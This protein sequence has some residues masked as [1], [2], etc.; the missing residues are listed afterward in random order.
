MYR[1]A[2]QRDL[3]YINGVDSF[4]KV[5]KANSPSDGFVY[6]PCVDCKNQKQFQNVEQIRYHLLRKGFMADYKIWNKHWEKGENETMQQTPRDKFRKQ[7]FQQAT[8]GA[9]PENE[10]EH[11]KETYMENISETFANTLA[12]DDVVNDGIDRMIRDAE[13]ECLDARNLKKLQQMRKDAK[14]PL[15]QGATMSKLEADLLLLEM[16]ATN[17]LSDTGFD[18]L[19]NI[20]DKILPSP[21][22]LP[23]NTY[24]AKQ[25]ICP[26]GLTFVSYHI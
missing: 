12:A 9:E 4:V 6:C 11:E 25:I 26:I 16:K 7:L 13:P 17:G 21:N 5:A 19:L 22:G 18:D 14:T 2:A 20:L 8:Q 1:P 23:K 10:S 24:Q 15:Y 3:I